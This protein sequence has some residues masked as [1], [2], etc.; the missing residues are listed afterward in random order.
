MVHRSLLAL[1]PGLG[2]THTGDHTVGLGNHQRSNPVAEFGIDLSGSDR[3]VLKGVVKGSGGEEFLVGS[4][5]RDYGNSLERMDDIR[6]TL[7]SP[8]GTGV[9]LYG[10]EY[11]PV[12]KIGI[13]RIVCHSY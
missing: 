6:E 12:K 13:K 3:C 8:F 1:V 7:A 5:C 9:G 4:H 2:L 10:E 11:R